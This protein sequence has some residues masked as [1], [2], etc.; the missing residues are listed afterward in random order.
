MHVFSK[1][2]GNGDDR[3]GS[4]EGEKNLKG[5]KRGRED[6]GERRQHVTP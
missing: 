5:K 4:Q 2:K 1:P 6:F 3:G